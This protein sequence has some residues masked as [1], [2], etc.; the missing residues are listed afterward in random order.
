MS[1]IQLLA[2]W[3]I[4]SAATRFMISVFLETAHECF[5]AHCCGGGPVITA[6][7]SAPPISR[8][9]EM[10]FDPSKY[11]ATPLRP[12]DSISIFHAFKLCPFGVLTVRDK[13]WRR[14]G[15]AYHRNLILVFGERLAPFH[16]LDQVV[17]CWSAL[18]PTGTQHQWPQ[19]TNDRVPIQF[20]AKQDHFLK[21]EIRH[22]TSR[23]DLEL[24]RP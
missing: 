6:T 14:E 20:H 18:V 16:P 13:R 4:T 5:S 9:K 12:V 17:S 2:L 15:P 23:R 24:I 10:T 22:T 21:D 7:A 11:L 8:P 3:R 19:L 1:A